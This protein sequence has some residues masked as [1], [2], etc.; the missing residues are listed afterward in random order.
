MRP[1]QPAEVQCPACEGDGC[2]ECKDGWFEVTQCPN[3]FIGSELIDDIRIATASEHHL[4]VA[5]GLLDQSAWWFE[6]RQL[7][8]SEERRIQDDRDNRK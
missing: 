1:D 2:G 4:P 8:Q 5:G 3:K 6:L 7:L